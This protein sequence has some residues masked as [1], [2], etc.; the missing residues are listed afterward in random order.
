MELI[1]GGAYQ[2]QE[3]LARREN[4]DALIL[5]DFQET[6]REALSRGEDPRALARRV[7]AEQPDAVITANEVGAGVVPLKA[8]DRAWREGVGRALFRAAVETLRGETRML[9]LST[10]TKDWRRILHFYIDE[11]GMDFWSARLFKEITG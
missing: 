8:E 4:P 5:P 9:L 6:V 3:E 11:L 1:I 7:I 10:A 2:G